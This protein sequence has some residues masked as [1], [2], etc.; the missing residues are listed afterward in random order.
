MSEILLALLI[1]GLMGLVGQGARATVGLKNLN[2]LSGTGVDEQTPFS[3]A[4]L[5][6]SLMIG[7]IAGILAAFVAG[8]HKVISVT[9]ADYSVLLAIAAAG[10]AG[11][12][13]V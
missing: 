11:A 5:L 2:R 13:F 9:E 6:I 12:D 4:Y 1:S 7:F 3:A 8:L 10:Y